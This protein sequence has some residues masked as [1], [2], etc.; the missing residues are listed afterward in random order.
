MSKKLLIALII[1][2]VGVVAYLVYRNTNNDEEIIIDDKDGEV[3]V[4]NA[5]VDEIEIVI[6]ETDPVQVRVIAKGNFP[7]GCTTIG[8]AE[9]KRTDNVFDVSIKTRRPKDSICTEAL[10]PF[11]E[12]VSLDVL[13]LSKGTY[14]VNVNG[15]SK[16]FTLNDDNIPPGK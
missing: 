7:D 16:T 9:T 11:E 2:A 3:V 15:I 12:T 1:I 10:V 4:R 6:L 13:N 14:T 8:K 5:N